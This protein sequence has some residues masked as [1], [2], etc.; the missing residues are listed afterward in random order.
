MGRI[1]E[2]YEELETE[3]TLAQFR[4]RV[5]AKV[6]EMGGLADTETAA[7]LVAH[8]I[9][10]D[11]PIDIGEVEPEMDAVTVLAAVRRVGEVHTFERED[12]STGSV[13]NVDIADETEQ[14]RAV[15]WDEGAT[16]AANTLERGDTLRLKARPRQ[17]RDGLELSV[18]D[19]RQERDLE[20]GIEP[21]GP[22]PI[23]EL[24]PGD[25]GVIIEGE[26]LR[27]EAPR[28]FEREDGE[29]GRVATIVLGDE[30]GAVAVTLW[31]D[32]AALAEELPTGEVVRAEGGRV[33]ERDGRREV[34]LGG[35][36]YLA[37]IDSSITY[38]PN[39]TPVEAVSEGAVVTLSGVIRSTDPVRTFDRDDGSEGRVRN[40]RLQ[41][42][43][44]SIR[45]ALWGD[46]AG[47][48]LA[49]GDDLTCIDVT[50]Q[51][52]YRDDL[53]ASANWRSTILPG[54]A[55]QADLEAESGSTETESPSGEVT[56][57]G[58][59]VQP[60]D[61]IILDD[62]SETVRVAYTGDVEL[63]ARVEVEGTREDDRIDAISLERTD[64]PE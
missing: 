26:V 58:T 49:P 20:V 11:R 51:E 18:T 24:V 37:S 48:E 9:E 59:V 12:G 40:L 55:G 63:G 41:D 4:E 35:R 14:V 54:R 64:R 45:V 32:A 16:Q 30:T 42:T 1:E 28:T 36:D 29:D 33:R 10:G 44:G 3:V 5:E 39:P 47:L 43:T 34:H 25:D 31:D 50:I 22:T 62:G 57:T 23:G 60:G 27:C 13:L 61:P 38:Q 52:G 15:F 19:V 17:G 46:H 8:E 7:M 6:E 53:E 56:F 2:L 21:P